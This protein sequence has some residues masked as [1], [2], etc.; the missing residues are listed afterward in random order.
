MKKVSEFWWDFRD[1]AVIVESDDGRYPIIAKFTFDKFGVQEAE[2]LVFDLYAG[3]KNYR[4]LAK[5]FLI[6][7]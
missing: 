5:Q 4:K 1:E 3:R 2:Q 6:N 7:S